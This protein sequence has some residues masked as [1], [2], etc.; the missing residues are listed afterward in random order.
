MCYLF[1]A[2]YMVRN[3]SIAAEA[4]VSKYG[5]GDH[6]REYIEPSV[7][8]LKRRSLH[9]PRQQLQQSGVEARCHQKKGSYNMDLFNIYESE[10]PDSIRDEI[11]RIEAKTPAA[12]QRGIRIALYA[13]ITVVG[14]LLAFANVFVSDLRTGLDPEMPSIREAGFGWVEDNPFTSFLFLNKIGGLLFLILGGGSGLL[15]EA[16]FDSKRINA[17]NIF[18][19]LKRRREAKSSSP[20][21]A[22][23][24]RQSTKKRRSGKESKRINALSEVV[25]VLDPPSANVNGKYTNVAVKASAEKEQKV[26]AAEKEDE[27]STATGTA[28]DS[29]YAGKQFFDTISAF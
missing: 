25:E 18:E 29:A 6:R 9:I 7:G 20:A 3:N 1:I 11:Y 4:F 24:S 8:R 19:E 14:I 13:C 2:D 27:D 21:E 17:E 26:V 5:S 15:A 10:I 22:K 16:E 23:S 12:Q 28:A